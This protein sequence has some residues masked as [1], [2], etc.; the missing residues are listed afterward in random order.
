MATSPPLTPSSHVPLTRSST[1][2]HRRA[3]ATTASPQRGQPAATETHGT[4][5]W[6]V[7]PGCT[8]FSRTLWRSPCYPG[9]QISS[10]WSTAGSPPCLRS[11]ACCRNTTEHCHCPSGPVSIQMLE[12]N[13]AASHYPGTVDFTLSW[14][15]PPL[16]QT[17]GIPSTTIWTGPETQVRYH[18]MSML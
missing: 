14:L 15:L 11:G 2:S 13:L 6:R 12:G 17:R 1:P 7:Q 5:R 9:M 10:G 4:S 3:A 16:Q 8:T 18:I